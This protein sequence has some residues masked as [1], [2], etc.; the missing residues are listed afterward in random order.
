MVSNRVSGKHISQTQV[1]NSAG[2]REESLDELIEHGI[3]SAHVP[4]ADMFFHCVQRLTLRLSDG[5]FLLWP[6]TG[7]ELCAL[8]WL[9]NNQMVINC[10]KNHD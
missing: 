4:I 6:M 9:A 7:L 10:V 3:C 5:G 8:M 1:S 2:G